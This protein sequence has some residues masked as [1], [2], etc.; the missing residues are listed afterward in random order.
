MH[1]NVRRRLA[2]EPSL[3]PGLLLARPGRHA[4]GANGRMDA[5]D[6]GKSSCCLIL[7]ARLASHLP[8]AGSAR[9]RQI[10]VR[11]DRDRS[12]QDIMI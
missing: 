12:F 5:P 1:Q 9:E 4:N 6:G 11:H 2:G 8:P 10:M 7:A 3:R